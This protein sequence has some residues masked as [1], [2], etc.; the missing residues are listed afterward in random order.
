M[1]KMHFQWNA[2]D[3]ISTWDWNMESE[4]TAWMKGFICEV[5][6]L[7]MTE[8]TKYVWYDNITWF[9]FFFGRI[10]SKSYLPAFCINLRTLQRNERNGVRCWVLLKLSWVRK[11]EAWKT[12]LLYVSHYF[13][14][15]W[16][17]LCELFLYL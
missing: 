3:I 12:T 6:N 7:S 1:Y 8:Y 17:F 11:P 14:F 4:K 16:R 15:S 9:G 2:V 10:L 5:Q 13:C